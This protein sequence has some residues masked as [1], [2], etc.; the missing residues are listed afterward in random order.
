MCSEASASK[1][2]TACRAPRLGRFGER[3]ASREEI[4]HVPLTKCLVT[5]ALKPCPRGDLNPHALSRALAPQASASTY[6]A[7]R[8][9]P[10]THG[11]PPNYSNRNRADPPVQAARNPLGE[12]EAMSSD[13]QP[14]AEVVG[15]CAELI[16]I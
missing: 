2:R 3:A 9:G 10:Q 7:T 16:R 1:R 12:D 6:S 5:L 15:L 8:T 11:A 14:D 4:D 13:Y